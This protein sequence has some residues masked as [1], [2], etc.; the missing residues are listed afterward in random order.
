MRFALILLFSLQEEAPLARDRERIQS[1]PPLT[2]AQKSA[3]SCADAPPA[4]PLSSY[5]VAVVPL[6]F[7]DQKVG[8]TDLSK[9]VFGGVN[10]YFARA[11]SGH[12]K[13]EGKVCPAVSLDLE[14]G[15]F[16]RYH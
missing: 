1:K 6:E 7:S 8:P 2:A 16:D 12:F 11:S 14:R 3:Y 15:R 10:D 5:T 4:K 9:L 13:L